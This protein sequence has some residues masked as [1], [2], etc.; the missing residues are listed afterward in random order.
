MSSI[1]IASDKLNSGKTMARSVI[2]SYLKSTGISVST[3]SSFYKTPSSDR[4]IIDLPEVET[5]PGLEDIDVKN[6]PDNMAR[7][8]PN[9]H[10]FVSSFSERLL[11]IS[12]SSKS[13]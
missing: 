9:L 2:L 5:I 10:E 3:I 1:I 11:R 7:N 13:L 8:S 4:Q 6:M 12:H